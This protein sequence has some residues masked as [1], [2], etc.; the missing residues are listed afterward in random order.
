MIGGDAAN[1]DG[2]RAAGSHLLHD[3]EAI[4][5]HDFAK[6]MPEIGGGDRRVSLVTYDRSSI[7]VLRVEQPADAA[8]NAVEELL[9]FAA[10]SASALL[11]FGDALAHLYQRLENGRPIELEL[12]P[13]A[14]DQAGVL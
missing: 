3:L 7:A 2:A 8:A 10:V 12:K 14:F 4:A 1:V 9:C 6:C 13:V 11:P 5:R